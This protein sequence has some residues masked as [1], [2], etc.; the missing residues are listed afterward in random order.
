MAKRMNFRD[1]KKKELQHHEVWF[2][3]VSS[4]DARSS[5]ALVFHRLDLVFHYR[6]LLIIK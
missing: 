2:V 1:E 4:L 3:A 6:C 5:L